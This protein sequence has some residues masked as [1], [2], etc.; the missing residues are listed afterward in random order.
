MCVLLMGIVLDTLE[1]TIKIA[2]LQT[3]FLTICIIKGLSLIV[4]VRASPLDVYSRYEL[5][6]YN[7]KL[8]VAF[9][10]CLFS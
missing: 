7:K 10:S 8:M 5:C 3:D 1:K 9:W 2:T 6:F 4:V